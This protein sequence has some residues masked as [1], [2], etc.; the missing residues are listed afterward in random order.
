MA[1]VDAVENQ[2]MYR[3][4]TLISARSEA[5]PRKNKYEAITTRR[6]PGTNKTFSMLCARVRRN[7]ERRV[8][9]R[10]LRQIG[11]SKQTEG[12][13]GC[14]RISAE[15]LPEPERS[16]PVVPFLDIILEPEYSDRKFRM[17]NLICSLDISPLFDRK[18]CNW[19]GKLGVQKFGTRIGGTRS[20]PEKNPFE[21]ERQAIE[22]KGSVSA[23]SEGR[24]TGTKGKG[25]LSSGRLLIITGLLITG[26]PVF[27]DH[28][29]PPLVKVSA[30]T[31]RLA[32]AIMLLKKFKA[33]LEFNVPISVGDGPSHAQISGFNQFFSCHLSRKGR[34]DIMESLAQ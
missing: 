2:D 34:F 4:R 5:D 1:I 31:L 12:L 28:P 19:V 24:P 32:D 14:T 16:G 22:K 11:S 17:F 21:C 9:S 25:K 30:S 27:G 18:R 20:G 3:N 33:C 23:L 8:F 26:V 29:M 7:L 15:N 13:I 10:T 6:Q